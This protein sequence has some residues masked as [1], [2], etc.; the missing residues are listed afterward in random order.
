M[1]QPLTPLSHASTSPPASGMFAQ[2]LHRFI[3]ARHAHANRTACAAMGVDPEL[4]Y[5]IVDSIIA[6]V[7]NVSLRFLS[8]SN[9]IGFAFPPV[10]QP[11][12]PKCQASPISMPISNPFPAFFR[13]TDP[14]AVP[15]SLEWNGWEGYCFDEVVWYWNNNAKDLCAEHPTHLVCSSVVKDLMV[16]SGFSCISIQRR[17][18]NK[19]AKRK[20]ESKMAEA[21]MA[22]E[23]YQKYIPPVTKTANPSPRSLPL[24]RYA[25]P[26]KPLWLPE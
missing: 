5:H 9:C 13:T 10:L 22:K 21:K 18:R 17:W 15:C 12:F 11:I 8:D 2:D 16:K 1:L 7:A 14:V 20:K 4:E 6:D 23:R 3:E 24:P 26:K 25:S 19:V